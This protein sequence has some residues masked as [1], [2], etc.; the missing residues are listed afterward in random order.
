MMVGLMIVKRAMKV[1]LMS[2]M[3]VVK[4]DGDGGSSGRGDDGM[5]P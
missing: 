4:V 3:I 5:H 2:V 1:V